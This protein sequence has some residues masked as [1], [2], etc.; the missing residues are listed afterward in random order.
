MEAR[1]GV[2]RGVYSERIRKNVL[3]STNSVSGKELDPDIRV[4]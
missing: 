2:M 1:L 4:L 3:W